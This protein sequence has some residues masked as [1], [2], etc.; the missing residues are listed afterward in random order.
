M[1][2][3]LQL[4]AAQ[5]DK[6]DRVV[7]EEEGR[8]LADTLGLPYFETSAKNRINV[9]ES[10][11]QGVREARKYR[12]A[13]LEAQKATPKKTRTLRNRPKTTPTLTHSADDVNAADKKRILILGPSGSGKR[14][15]AFAAAHDGEVEDNLDPGAYQ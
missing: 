5:I 6:E 1:L 15:L 7:T 14:S 11:Y 2:L 8:A 12:A 10:F 13:Q 4:C 3:T 9:E